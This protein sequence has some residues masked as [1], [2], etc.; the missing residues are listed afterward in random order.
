MTTM[1][2]KQA[3]S[4]LIVLLVSLGAYAIILLASLRPDNQ[5]IIGDFTVAGVLV[6]IILAMYIYVPSRFRTHFSGLV[7]MTVFIILLMISTSSTIEI[8]LVLFFVA[9]LVYFVFYLGIY[10]TCI[11]QVREDGITNEEYIHDINVIVKTAD[12]EVNSGFLLKEKPA[13]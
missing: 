7:I 3:T 8:F 9:D 12:K 6:F 13:A 11:D 1:K 4:T 5:E 10:T 2:P